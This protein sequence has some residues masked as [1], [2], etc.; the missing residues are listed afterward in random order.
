MF[1]LVTWDN[2]DPHIALAG[3]QSGMFILATR[4]N[5]GP[6][7]PL[8]S[9]QNINVY[10][11]YTGKQGSSRSFTIS[12]CAKTD[13]GAINQRGNVKIGDNVTITEEIETVQLSF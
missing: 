5:R 10:P 1:I 4:V 12:W 11:G 3:A 2:R 8:D 13:E 9:A 6:H 7:V